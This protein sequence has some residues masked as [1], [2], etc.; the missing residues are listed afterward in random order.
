M[1]LL[2]FSLRVPFRSPPHHSISIRRIVSEVYMGRGW[3]ALLWQG[4][5]LWDWGELSLELHVQVALPSPL[6]VAFTSFVIVM[7]NLFMH[8]YLLVPWAQL[9]WIVK[10]RGV[11][12]GWKRP[13]SSTSDAPNFPSTFQHR[14]CE[15]TS[16]PPPLCC[17]GMPPSPCPRVR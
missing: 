14:V 13:P 15:I 10:P 12:V 4:G 17:G 7:H 3:L 2:S 11:G 1:G 16:S 5:S 9:P 6:S 8:Q